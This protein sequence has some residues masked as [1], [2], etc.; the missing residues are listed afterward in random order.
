MAVLALPTLLLSLDVSVLYLAL[1]ELSADLGANGVEQ[2]WILDIYSFLLAGCLV[3]MGTLGDRIGRR[4]LLLIGGAAFGILSVL[5]AYSS[6]PELLILSRALLGIAGASLMPSTMALIRNMFHDPVQLGQA[7]GI[8]FSCFIGG[9]LVGPVIGGVLLEQFWWGSVF[10]LGVPVM[11]LLL[12]LGPILLPEYS[13]ES[14]G[15]IDLLSVLLSLAAILPAIW[16]LKELAR[17]GWATLPALAIVAGV[18]IGIT[19]A[20]RQHRLADPLLDM[21]LFRFPRFSAALGVMLAAG[22]VMAGISFQ[23]AV[24]LQVVGGL[25]PLQAG[26]WLIPQNVT[27]VIGLNLAPRIAKR[28]STAQTMALGLVLAAAGLLITMGADGSGRVGALVAGLALASFGIGLPMALTMNLV[29]ASAPPE[30]AGS[31]ASMSETSSEAGIALGIASLGSLG[32]VVYRGQLDS[33]LP[34]GLPDGWVAQARQGVGPAIA[35]AQQLPGQLGSEM[36]L[37]AKAAFASGLRV[38]AIA[39]AVLLLGSALLTLTVL[40]RHTDVT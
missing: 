40:R 2:L 28:R 6:S 26:L 18:A 37:V 10:L 27:M 20:R 33:N 16:G 21:R 31:A 23:A 34:A 17:S 25:S 38:V 9:M 1:P 8:W 24:Y 13:D 19:F 30:R 14:A 15:R 32:T 12:I 7:I 5:A 39:G 36:E 4:R 22:V 35:A 29:L 3:T 11:V